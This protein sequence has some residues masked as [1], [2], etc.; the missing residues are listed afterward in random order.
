[1]GIFGRLFGRKPEQ[2]AAQK[3]GPSSTEET[4]GER[5]KKPVSSGLV[6][7]GELIDDLVAQIPEATPIGNLEPIC[8]YCDVTLPKMPKRAIKC[9]SCKNK[10]RVETRPYD[11]QRVMATQQQAEEIWS[12]QWRQS[13]GYR[14]KIVMLKR[15]LS[16]YQ[17]SGMAGWGFL[18]VLDDADKPEFVRLHGKPFKFGSKGEIEALKLMVR[19][20]SRCCPIPF[21]NDPGLNTDQ[22]VYNKER[23][24]WLEKRGFSL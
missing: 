19:P 10:I 18:A 11:G 15:D 2:L 9:P 3:V 16:R 22:S 12:Q 21:S 8:P 20:D 7:Y 17:K 13:D 24:E 5:Q 4:L 14:E 6:D 23:D 1:M